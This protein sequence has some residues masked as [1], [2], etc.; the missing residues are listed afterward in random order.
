MAISWSAGFA[1]TIHGL[2]G[3]Y[4]VHFSS[5]S[6]HMYSLGF[7]L[8]TTTAAA[9]YY[10]LNRIWPVPLYPPSREPGPRRFETMGKTDGFFYDEIPSS[11]IEGID[12][13]E[14]G[15]VPVADL[16]DKEARNK[17]IHI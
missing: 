14:T 12:G 10:I 3:S 15:T 8:A 7:P 9:F 4:N 11:V 2:A 17:E 16:D 1:I 13:A 6:K 5:A